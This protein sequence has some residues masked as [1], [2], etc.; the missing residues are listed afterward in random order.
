MRAKEQAGKGW[1]PRLARPLIA[2]AVVRLALLALVLV[3][4]GT[5]ALNRPDTAS[6]LEPGRNLLL[7]GEFVA[8]G[9]PEISRTPG[10]PLFLA[11]V[12]LAGPVAA[13]LAQ[14]LL[15]VFSV[16]LV[17][18]LARTVFHDNRIA[19]A[20]AWIFAFEPLSIL[21]SILLLSETL[22]LALFLLSLE[23]VAAFLREQRLSI[24]AQAG[25]C[26]AAATFVRPVSYYLPVVLAVGLFAALAR[27]PGLPPQRH[28]PVAGDPG[29]PPQRHGPVAGDPGLPP[30]RHG[31]VAGDPGLRWKAPAVLLLSTLPWLA[32]WQI[33][34]Q[35]ETGFGGFS[36]AQAYNLYFFSA[37]EVTGRVEHRSVVSVQNDFGY[38]D[39]QLF[40][41]RHP[42][43][44]GWNQAQRLEFMRA[45]TNRVLR[46]HPGLFLRAQL[47]GAVRTAFNPSASIF[48]SVLNSSLDDETYLRER[49]QGPLRAALWAARAHPGQTAV[50]AALEAVLLVLYF[51][52]AKGTL[53][54]GAPGV[55][56]WLLLG[57][58]LYFLG[59]SGVLGAARFRLPVMPVVCTLAAAGVLR[60]K[61]KIA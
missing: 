37:A 35:V 7:H 29:L 1:T 33:R 46:A 52:A 23:R 28:G 55:C 39:E 43:A 42:A 61:E 24:L 54:G 13:A 36:S 18:R 48:I 20:A 40:L 60:R 4:S 47:A 8:S 6:Y 45:E 32:L 15:S 59:V 34:N 44:A 5:S 19:L 30:Q 10:Y 22:F 27:V 26:L 53:R 14:V 57:V 25:V 49:S 2:A 51:F 17:W 31:P 56:L 9:L 16:V 12:S 38:N 41:A 50:M 58:S 21:Y 3:R 11:L